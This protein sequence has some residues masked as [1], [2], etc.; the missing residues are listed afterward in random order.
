MTPKSLALSTLSIAS[1]N[2]FL[3]GSNYPFLA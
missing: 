3:A 1:S 2:Y